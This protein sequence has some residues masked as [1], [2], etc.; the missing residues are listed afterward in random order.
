MILRASS[1]RSHSLLSP[2]LSYAD[3]GALKVFG[4]RSL[5]LSVLA[6][7]FAGLQALAE[8]RYALVFGNES[9]DP[10][11]GVLSNP[12]ED[13][14]KVAAAL[15]QVGFEVIGGVRKD[16]DR[17]AIW[18]GIYE[19]Q[20]KL[21]EAGA[22]ATGFVFYAG[23]GGSHEARGERSNYLIPVGPAITGGKPAPGAWC[24]SWRCHWHA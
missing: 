19:L 11:V 24:R 1:N 5:F 10:R 4:M 23:H 21:T 13:A 18:A 6:L 22:D 14:E 20:S 7:M 8:E 2:V 16:A 15:R 9:Y 3:F 17:A 12:H